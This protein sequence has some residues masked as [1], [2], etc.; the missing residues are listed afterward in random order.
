MSEPHLRAV[1]DGDPAGRPPA[2]AGPESERRW[3]PLALACALALA[4]VL[5]LWSRVELG[6]RISALE[7]EVG[8]LEATVEQR[9][10]VIAAHE[11]R[12]AT[13]R[14]RISEL[15]VLLDEPLQDGE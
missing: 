6:Q 14:E 2:T 3:V 5:L 1:S 4:L 9:E 11:R 12:A 8:A 15:Q 7:D 10:R 13:V